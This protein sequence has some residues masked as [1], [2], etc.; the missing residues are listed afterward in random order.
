LI[1]GKPGHH[2][3]KGFQNYPTVS[4]PVSKGFL[5]YMRRVLD[6]FF[7][8]EVPNE[9]FLSEKEAIAN[10][11]LLEDKNT[12]TWLGHSTFLL[13]ID[14]ITILTDPFL[15]EFA[16]PVSFG[17]ARRFIPPG[18]TI[19]N[20]PPIDIILV[21]H[22]HYDHLDLRTIEQLEKKE[23]IIVFVPLG[24]KK[25]FSSRGYKTVHE[26]D[27]EDSFSV[28]NLRLVALPAVHFSGRGFND[29]NKTLWCSWAILTS[30]GNYFFS[31]DT[32]YSPL[33]FRAIGKKYK[34]FALSILPIG[35]YEP[36]KLQWTSHAIPEETV[37]IGLDLNAKVLVASH[38]GTIKLSDEP[39]W[40][41]PERFRKAAISGDLEIENI[42]I[43]K[44][45]ETRILPSLTLKKRSNSVK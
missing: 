45:G 21:S 2:T 4:A 37:G 25:Y 42:W 18:I 1:E 15:T 28:N 17:G 39:L 32:G 38:W 41:P 34:S 19:D 6:S 40:E 22:N 27:W 7:L 16:S 5:F 30:T 13:R 8:P 29:K 36:R 31:G 44:I 10:F 43:M 20:L 26:L 33:I 24:L 3:T 12:I 23:K 35:A 11:K 9:H 14:G